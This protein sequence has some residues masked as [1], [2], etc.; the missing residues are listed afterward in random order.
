MQRMQSTHEYLQKKL[1]G[2]NLDF[3]VE[4]GIGTG[5]GVGG[6]S[7]RKRAEKNWFHSCFICSVLTGFATLRVRARIVVARVI[8]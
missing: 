3:E 7:A 6:G 2:W 5:V 1:A 8:Q 4:I